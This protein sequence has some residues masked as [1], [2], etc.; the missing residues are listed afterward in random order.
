MA[1]NAKIMKI[2]IICVL[3]SSL[4][5]YTTNRMDNQIHTSLYNAIY[6]NQKR[7]FEDSL[8]SDIDFKQMIVFGRKSR[9]KLYEAHN[10]DINKHQSYIIL[11]G[12]SGIGSIYTGIVF[13]D[14]I[15]IAYIHTPAKGWQVATFGKSNLDSLSTFTYIDLSIINKVSAWDV[16]YINGRKQYVGGT[17]VT[18]GYS[19]IATRVDNSKKSPYIETIGFREFRINY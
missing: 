4:F 1:S 3:L 8:N 10:I 14:N 12:N 9:Q 18:D 2:T 17:G 19:F 11:E 6:E 15:E 16:D 7:Y 5:S 13:E